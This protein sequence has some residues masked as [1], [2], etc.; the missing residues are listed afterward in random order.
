MSEML[1]V[2]HPLRIQLDFRLSSKKEIKLYVNEEMYLVEI[3]TY[4]QFWIQ[5]GVS[6][7]VALL[8][9]ESV[10]KSEK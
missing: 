9:L 10:M 1:N 8:F 6:S 5:P 3:F 4:M 2:L 7:G